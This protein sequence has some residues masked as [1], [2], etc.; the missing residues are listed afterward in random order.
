M[1][2]NPAAFNAHLK[3]IGQRYSWRKSYACPCI[4]PHSGAAKTSCL[5]C[6]GRGRIWDPGVTGVAGMAGVKVQRQWAQFGVYE[7][8][9][10]VVTIGSSTPLYGMG[11]FDRIVALDATDVF[12]QVLTRGQGDR[13]FGPIKNVSRVFWLESNQAIVEGGIPTVS[14]TGALTWSSGAPPSG[15]QYTV[16]GERYSEY[17]CFME[18][19]GDRNEHQG[20]QLPRRVVLRKFDLFSRQGKTN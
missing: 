12:S 16:C 17:F 1:R 19:P 6:G 8:G 15:V 20:A 3:H 11:Q 7:N 10:V 9:D 14:S 18:L 2:L 13:L 5:Q 4:A